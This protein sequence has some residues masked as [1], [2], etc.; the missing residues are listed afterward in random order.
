MRKHPIPNAIPIRVHTPCTGQRISYRLAIP[1]VALAAF[2]TLA[3]LW[4]WHAHACYFAVLK[5]FGFEP[6]R[7]PFLDVQAVL[8]A[9]QCQR[10]GIDVYRWNPCDALGRVHVYSPFWFVVIPRF[11]GTQQTTLVGLALD[12]AAILSLVG[13][14]RPQTAREMIVFGLVVLSP[15][16][17]YALERAN[18]DVFAFLLVLAGCMLDR[19]PS[20]WRLGCYAFYLLVGLLRYYPL[21]L[22]VLLARESKHIACGGA[23]I[24]TAIMLVL[25]GIGRTDLVKALANIPALSYYAD[26][27]S[28]LNLPFGLSEMLAKFG[29]GRMLGLVLLSLLAAAGIARTIRT[30]PLLHSVSFDW[31]DREAQCMLVGALLLT[32]CFVAGQNVVYRAIYILFVIPGLLRMRFLA[33]D[34]AVRLF[35]GRMIATIFSSLGQKF[36]VVSSTRRW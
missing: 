5:L 12:L 20:R 8:S 29:A 19:A 17:V 10:E 16:T 31:N 36:F 14:L 6:F 13:V 7:F 28:A 26:L 21:V 32:A 23:A 22:L 33:E 2:I 34:R 18:S 25:A 4:H 11:L 15:V 1:A 9:A 35:L 3:L 24:A 27:F 30:L